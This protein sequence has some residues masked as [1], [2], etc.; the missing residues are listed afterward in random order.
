MKNRQQFVSE[1]LTHALTFV[2]LARD[3][4]FPELV[5]QHL[6]ESERLIEYVL[7]VIDGKTQAE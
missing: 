2:R 5:K 6:D 4:K 3:A 1:Q 7:G